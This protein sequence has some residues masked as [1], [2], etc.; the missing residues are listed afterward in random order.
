[1]EKGIA[2]IYKITNLK[3]GKVYIGFDSSWPL[4]VRQHKTL[5]LNVNC[6]DYNKIL[7]KSI[8]KYGLENFSFDVIYQSK[9]TE[10]CKNV[11]ENFFIHEYKSFIGFEDCYGYN[12]TLGGDG[13]FGSKRPKSKEFRKKHSKLMSKNNPRTG[14]R[15]TDEEKQKRS[16]TMKKFYSEHPEKRPAGEKNGM[17]SKTH[18]DEWRKNHSERMKKNKNSV[19]AMSKKDICKYCGKETTIGNI[20]RWHNENCKL[21]PENV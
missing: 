17:F 6:H 2:T 3:T 13:T 8:R 18:S 7:Y 5:A 12:M 21:K 14:Y 19:N 4:R 9:D 20:S 15:Y 16:E 1:M 10:H 11:M